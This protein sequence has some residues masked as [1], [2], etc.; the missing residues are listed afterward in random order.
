MTT[1]TRCRLFLFKTLSRI[2]QATPCRAGSIVVSLYR[3]YLL[4]SL[5][6][7]AYHWMTYG[8]IQIASP[9]CTGYLQ[10]VAPQEATGRYPLLVA[11]LA[12]CLRTGTPPLTNEKRGLVVTQAYV[13]IS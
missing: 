8:G 11:K 10:K 13:V 9:A 2:H 7:A 5:P 3:M 12:G 1:E 4:L 6:S